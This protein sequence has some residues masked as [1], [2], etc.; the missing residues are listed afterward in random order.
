MIGK[1]QVYPE[2]VAY[3]NTCATDS[4]FDKVAGLKPATLSKNSLWHRCFPRNFVKFLGTPFFTEHL[5]WLFLFIRLLA[6]RSLND[7]NNK[8]F[9]IRLQLHKKGLNLNMV[10][11]SFYVLEL[12]SNKY[13]FFYSLY[14]FRNSHPEVFYEK[15][16]LQ[17]Y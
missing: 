14:Y 4:F 2:T 1:T 17:L 15:G 7:S 6:S 3:E 9:L 12:P 16:A 13:K 11:V 5:S 8:P 10:L